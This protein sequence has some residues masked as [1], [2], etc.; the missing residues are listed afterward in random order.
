LFLPRSRPAPLNRTNGL[1]P[2]RCV[3]SII[4]NRRPLLQGAAAPGHDLH[5]SPSHGGSLTYLPRLILPTPFSF[6]VPTTSLAAH[7]ICHPARRPVQMAVYS[8]SSSTSL[9]AKHQSPTAS[10]TPHTNARRL[11]L[12]PLF[13][14]CFDDLCF[15]GLLVAEHRIGFVA[16]RVA[17]GGFFL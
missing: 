2:R 5:A 8:R 9:P 11:V 13:Q 3:C 7:R 12:A 4:T 10:H 6:G 14:I 15:R 16:R 17:P 1:S